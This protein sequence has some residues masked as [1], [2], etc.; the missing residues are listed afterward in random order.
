MANFGAGVSRY[1]MVVYLKSGDK[2]VFYSLT[3]E[4]QKVPQ[5][6]VSNMVNRLLF[7]MY[8]GKYQTAMIYD[9]HSPINEAFQKWSLGHREY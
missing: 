5:K 7:G 9:T 4:E 2:K 6:V 1:K 3:N 8:R